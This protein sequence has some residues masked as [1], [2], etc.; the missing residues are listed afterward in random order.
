MR[1]IDLDLTSLYERCQPKLIN[2]IEYKEIW[3]IYMGMEIFVYQ[4][5]ALNW[6]KWSTK[7][8]KA[9]D[10]NYHSHK[11]IEIT[12]TNIGMYTKNRSVIIITPKR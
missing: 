6:V 5:R 11:H 12:Q 10:T 3:G 4:I 8:N 2:F 7:W 1:N 9:H